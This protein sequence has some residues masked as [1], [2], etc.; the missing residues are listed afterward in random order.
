K[1]GND[2]RKEFS[3]GTKTLSTERVKACKNKRQAGRFE[4]GPLCDSA[5]SGSIS[6][7]E[8]KGER[9]HE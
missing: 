8:E 7:S 5:F 4:P 6:T 9:N 3:N 1:K 2:K